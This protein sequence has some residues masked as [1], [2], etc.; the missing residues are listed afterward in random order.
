MKRATALI[1]TLF[2]ASGCAEAL[3]VAGGGV[4]GYWTKGAIDDG[5]LVVPDIF[6]SEDEQ[7]S[8]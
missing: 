4:I 5:T 2:L 3:Y 1:L 6:K 8:E 7:V